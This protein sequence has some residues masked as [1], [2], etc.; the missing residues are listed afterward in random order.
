[1]ETVVLILAAFVVGYALGRV[2]TLF[3]S[4]KPTST[5]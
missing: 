4:K 3:V 5:A 2:K 1:M